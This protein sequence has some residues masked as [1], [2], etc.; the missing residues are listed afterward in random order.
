MASAD[1]AIRAGNWKAA[2]GIYA[3]L[4]RDNPQTDNVV[5]LNNAAFARL[6]LGDA[7]S[8]VAL[9]RRALALAPND[10]TVLDTVGWALYKAQ[11]PSPEAVALL[12]RAV[13][14]MPDNANIRR[15]ANVVAR[16]V[17]GGA[18]V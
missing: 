10:P 12:R 17:Q 15:H 5:L 18:G 7:K 9:G 14:A 13:S 11:G 4:L 16:E 1:K 3:S 8:A 6:E 2:D